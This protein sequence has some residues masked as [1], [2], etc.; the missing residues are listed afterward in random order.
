MFSYVLFLSFFFFFTFLS[1]ILHQATDAIYVGQPCQRGPLFPAMTASGLP[2]TAQN[3]LNA[4][5]SAR[6]TYQYTNAVPQCAAFDTSQWRVW[7]GRIRQYSVQCTAAPLNGVLHLITGVSFVGVTNANST[8][9]IAAPITT[10]PPSPSAPNPPN[11]LNPP[12]PPNS[13]NPPINPA[14]IDKPNSIWTTGTCVPQNGTIK[15]FAVIG[16][17]VQIPA[18]MITQQITQAQLEA[19]IQ[20]D[21]SANGLKRGTVR[22]KVNLF[23]GIIKSV[24]VKLP[25]DEYPTPEK[26]R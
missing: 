19:I 25:E 22:E 23:P 5:N 20:F 26:S 9:P 10:M 24:D 2:K 8:S 21:V 1:G 14:A 12:D 18:G 17:N 15:S 4:A 3:P 11:Q 13:T 7:E 16:N 6:S